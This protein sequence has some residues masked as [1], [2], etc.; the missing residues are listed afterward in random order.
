[1]TDLAIHPLTPDRW[2]D[3]VA[4]F[5]SDSICRNCWCVAT[6][7]PGR[8]RS[9]MEPPAR[10]ARMAKEVKA[11]PPPGLLAYRGDQ[12]V[13]W[14]A[15]APRS[16]TPD[17]NAGRKSSAVEAESDA[18][19]PAV[20]AATC[21]FVH[22]SARKQGMTGDLL[23]AATDWAKTNGAERLEACPMSHDDARST[24]GL[25]VGPKRVFERAG[26]ETVLER[27]PG[28]PLM[29]LILGKTRAANATKGSK[30]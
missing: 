28:R 3:F 29:R 10:K 11:G 30:R 5:E 6:R 20:W 12:A 1:M 23:A 16:A 19:N 14:L 25:C 7:L 26:F 8:V 4:L 9:E 21:F 17:W 13:G 27:K 2:D 15:V 24:V 18:S 22:R